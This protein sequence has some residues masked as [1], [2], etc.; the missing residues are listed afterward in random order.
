MGNNAEKL[1]Y[2]VDEMADVLGICRPAAYALVN[3]EDF[4]AV[5]VSPRRIVIPVSAL[6]NWLEEQAKRKPPRVLPTPRA[7]KRNRVAE[8]VSSLSITDLE[9]KRK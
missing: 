8:P 4:P 6:S 1:V 2:S 3:R 7:A 9:D 5:R